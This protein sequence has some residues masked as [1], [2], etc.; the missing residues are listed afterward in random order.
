MVILW[1]LVFLLLSFT[2]NVKPLAFVITNFSSMYEP[3]IK[4]D[5]LLLPNFCWLCYVYWSETSHSLSLVMTAFCLSF[6][7][8]LP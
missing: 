6:L 5:F 3:L 1:F 8:I 2:Y 7:G 4:A